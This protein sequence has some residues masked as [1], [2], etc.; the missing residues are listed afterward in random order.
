VRRETEM[1]AGI[2]SRRAPFLPR[3]LVGAVHAPVMRGSYRAVSARARRTIVIASP[4]G[5][6]QSRASC[7]LLWIASSLRFSRRQH[8]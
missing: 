4:E 3:K 5:A 6:R 1:P 2:K 8:Q 7:V